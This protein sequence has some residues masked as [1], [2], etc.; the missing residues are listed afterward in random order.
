M[1]S[2]ETA[3]AN[4]TVMNRLGADYMNERGRSGDQHHVFAIMHIKILIEEDDFLKW[5]ELA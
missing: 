5:I 4:A 3:G 1:K 2:I